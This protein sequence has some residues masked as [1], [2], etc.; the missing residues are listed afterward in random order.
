VGISANV[1][2]LTVEE[3]ECLEE[4][5][6]KMD[7]EAPL[8]WKEG[9]GWREVDESEGVAG[10]TELIELGV[11]PEDDALSVVAVESMEED[12]SWPGPPLR[13]TEGA[14]REVIGWVRDGRVEGL[15]NRL[16]SANGDEFDMLDGW[17]RS[18]RGWGRIHWGSEAFARLLS[19]RG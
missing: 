6:V 9:G 2:D 11:E 5:L 14:C 10:K 16:L 17:N 13:L 1:T 3:V 7:L 15:Q 4:D 8:A 12:R 19:Y 18:C